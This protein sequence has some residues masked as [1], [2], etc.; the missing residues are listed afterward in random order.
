MPPLIPPPAI[1]GNV[2]KDIL[3][4]DINIADNIQHFPLDSINDVVRSAMDHKL[5]KRAILVP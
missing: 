4:G 1:H 5:E 3:A 2:V